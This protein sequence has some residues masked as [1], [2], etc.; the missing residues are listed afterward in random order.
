MTDT[1]TE[2][3]PSDD[4]DD[5]V[6]V[7]GE[8]VPEEAI[9]DDVPEWDDEYVDRVSD[10]LM[11]NYDLEKDRAVRDREFTLYGELKIESQK[12]FFHPAL[13]YAN[14]EQREHLFVRRADAVSVPDLEALVDLGH[15]LADEWIDADEEHFGTQFTFVVVAPEVPDDVREFVSGFKDRTLLKWGY[16]GDYE[17]TL[18]VVAPEREAAVGGES[19]DVTA[20]FRT[21]DSVPDPERPPGLLGRLARLLGR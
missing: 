15:D 12:E 1:T 21:W 6:T 5:E 8:T 11:F 10:R 17:V 2:S 19:A 3:S 9:P 18:A 7:A 16:Y 20:A 13:N 4:S 14:H